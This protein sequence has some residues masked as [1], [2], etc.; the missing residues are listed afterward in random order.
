MAERTLVDEF[1]YAYTVE[2]SPR[3]PM[4]VCMECQV[5]IADGSLPASH[6]YCP[7]CEARE[8]AKLDELTERPYQF[9]AR[10]QEP[11]RGG[12]HA[13]LLDAYRRA[14][15]GGM[16]LLGLSKRQDGL[17]VRSGR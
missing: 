10:H 17:D 4:R 9:I 13:D 1:G 16:S 14:Y 3:P 5:V 7:D 11:L 15:E 12:G 6:G 8:L 2:D